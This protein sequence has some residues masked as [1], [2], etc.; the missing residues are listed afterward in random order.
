MSGK[1]E[2]LNAVLCND[3]LSSMVKK[4][5][6]TGLNLKPDE[7]KKAGRFNKRRLNREFILDI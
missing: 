6:K 5:E 2:F 7:I 3:R 1:R 4:A